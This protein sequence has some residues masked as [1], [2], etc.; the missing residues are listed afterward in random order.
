MEDNLHSKTTFDGTKPLMEDNLRWRTTIDGRGPH[1][2]D[3][4]RPLMEEDQQHQQGP[5]L[6]SIKK[7]LN[8]VHSRAYSCLSTKTPRRVFC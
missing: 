4:R 2:L 5:S 6:K 1:V 7:E 3:G 8:T